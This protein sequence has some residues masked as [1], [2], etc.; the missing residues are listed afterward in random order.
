MGRRGL[1]YVSEHVMV[2]VEGAYPP[3]PHPTSDKTRQDRQTD[4]HK[5]GYTRAQTSD[6]NGAVSVCQPQSSL[7][8]DGGVVWE[9]WTESPTNKWCGHP[10]GRWRL[11]GSDRGNMDVC[12][13]GANVLTWFP[14][15]RVARELGHVGDEH[16]RPRPALS[17]PGATCPEQATGTRGTLVGVLFLGS[18]GQPG[19][20]R[21]MST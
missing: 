2:A 15:L 17:C 14:V 9:R 7:V 3:S 10:E 19:G 8:V 13:L 6:Q 4:G 11:C 1:Q 12:V 20:Q 5:M 18:R 16:G 21:K